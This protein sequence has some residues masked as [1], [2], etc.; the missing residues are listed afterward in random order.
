[1]ICF[2]YLNKMCTKAR[3]DI[4]SILI[5]NAFMLPVLLFLGL[6]A[7]E[8]SIAF[9]EKNDTKQ[10]AISYAGAISKKG[11]LIT[12]KELNELLNKSGENANLNDFAAR[13]RVIV[14]AFESR[15]GGLAPLKLWQRCSPQPAGKS[16]GTSYTSADITLPAGVTLVEGVTYVAVE[17]YYDAK[18][19]TGFYFAEKDANGELVKKLSGVFTYAAR[20]D[21]F[22]ATINDPD[23]GTSKASSTCI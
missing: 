5:E 21:A 7:A 14:T 6:G 20:E 13:G 2:S 10:L 9:M 12:E 3:E 23:G 4:G 11:G 15:A 19:V 22:T 17:A 8:I 18:P 1:M 16:F